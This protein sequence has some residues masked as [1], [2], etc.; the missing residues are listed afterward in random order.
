MKSTVTG[1]TAR[2]AVATH[3]GT[4]T[5]RPFL[6]G[7]SLDEL[8]ASKLVISSV[9]V[10]FVS[11]RG[12]VVSSYPRSRGHRLVTEGSSLGCEGLL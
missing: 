2:F 7:G 5:R 1:P 11:Y 6:G 4:T 3:D 8:A 10:E 12:N 9:R